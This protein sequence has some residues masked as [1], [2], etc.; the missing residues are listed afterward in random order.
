MA[1]TINYAYDPN[2][3]VYVIHKCDEHQPHVTHGVVIRIRS[4]II[5]SRTTLVY[6]IRL[7]GAY[8]T[9]EFEESDVF[10]DKATAIA[11]Y[12]TRIL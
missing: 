12:D 7:T 1:G 6:D 3:Q 9:H 11:E 2:Q 8:G 10:V 5:M 4:E